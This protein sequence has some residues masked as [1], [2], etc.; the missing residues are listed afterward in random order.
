MESQVGSLEGVTLSPS[1]ERL[2]WPGNR[3]VWL[4]VCRCPAPGSA[5]WDGCKVD[6]SLQGQ[7]WPWAHLIRNW[8]GGTAYASHS[9]RFPLSQYWMSK[10]GLRACKA[11]TPLLSH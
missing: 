7:P 4:G 6:R 10:P 8:K 3:Y 11:S 9:E 2:L 1:L 5:E